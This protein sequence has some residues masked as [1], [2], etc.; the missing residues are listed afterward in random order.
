MCKLNNIH[1]RLALAAVLLLVLPGTFCIAAQAADAE[2]VF[3]S[4]LIYA[5]IPDRPQC[6]AST[7]TQTADGDLLAAW[8][9][10]TAE[11][12]KDVAILSARLAPGATEWTEPGILNDAPDLSE[13]NPVLYTDPVGTVWFFYLVM[14]GDTWNDCK[15]HYRTSDDN[16]RTWGEEQTLISTKGYA[17][18]NRPVLL[19]NGTLLLPA[20]N[21]MLYTPLFILTRNNFRTMKKTG[22]N[23]RDEGGLD[24]PT[25][26]QLS[27]DSLLAYF[28]STQ[29]KGIIMQAASEDGGLTWS[30]PE[31]TEFPN[32]EAGIAM[33]R[34][35][36]GN[37]VL[38]YNDSAKSRSPL[39]VAMSADDGATWPWKRDL[40]VEPFEFSYPCVMQ[41]ADGLIHVTY[42]YK[43]THIKH[44]AFNETWIMQD[45]GGK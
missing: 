5:Q 29:V 40:E 17:L 3:E 22:T 25:V 30:G 10:G 27:D 11:K 28:R 13:G 26:V 6:H 33:E 24:Q 35:S 42:T 18:R 21:E 32:P 15:V 2:P 36:D 9:A 19:R 8:F 44:A 43:R 20:A 34:L 1:F 23:L 41:A 31:T 45:R 4:Q 16:G 14:Y 7:M 12:H 37:L 38:V 39:T